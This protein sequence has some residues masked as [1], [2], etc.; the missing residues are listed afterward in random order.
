M[1]IVRRKYTKDYKEAAAALAERE[2]KTV[3]QVARELGINT[4]ILAR[5]LAELRE[6][7]GGGGGQGISW[8]QESAGR[9]GG[10]FEEAYSR[11]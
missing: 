3:S 4:S 9:R 6:A 11:T 10:P 2:D 8:E 1:A 5:W 7:Q